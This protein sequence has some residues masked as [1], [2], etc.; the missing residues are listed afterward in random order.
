MKNILILLVL[1]ISFIPSYAQNNL[2]SVAT[3]VV[4]QGQSIATLSKNVST[5]KTDLD[6]VKTHVNAQ[7]E[8]DTKTN[9][10]CGICKISPIEWLL[11]FSPIWIFVIALFMIRRK[12]KDYNLKNAL[13]E[14]ELP[15][16]I[17]PNPEYTS[18]KINTLAANDTIAGILPTLLPPT[19][20][21]TEGTEYPKSSSRYIAFITSALTWIII[22]CLTCF[23]IYQYMKTGEAP[24]FDGISSILLALGIGVVPYAFNKIS[25]AVE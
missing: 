21:V 1:T 3:Q 19:I 5:I 23:F 10:A 25:K 15:K 16:K 8:N 4:N 11:I 2:D 22:L 24:K 12:L 20:E 17:I 18:E 14:S 13:A 6:T 9:K 7:K